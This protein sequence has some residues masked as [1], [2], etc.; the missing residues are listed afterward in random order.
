MLS[1]NLLPIEEK[2]NIEREELRRLIRFLGMGIAAVFFIASALLLPAYFPIALE[3]RE[4]T[5]ALAFEQDASEKLTGASIG[6]PRSLRVRVDAIRS[7]S[8][9]VGSASRIFG[10]LFAGAGDVRFHTISIKKDGTFALTGFARTRKE[11]LDFEK[12]FR[13][14]GKFQE[15]FFPL[16]NIVQESNINFSAQ[17]MLKPEY[18]L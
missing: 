3:R 12:A 11:L 6:S 15:V 1:I 13:A 9:G 18:R 16:S 5:R 8:S 4:L 14:S 2:R 7:L 10:D 17:G